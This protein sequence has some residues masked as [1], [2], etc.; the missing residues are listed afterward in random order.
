MELIGLR[1]HGYDGEH[2][3]LLH[4]GP[5]LKGRE[6]ERERETSCEHRSQDMFQTLMST[7]RTVSMCQRLLGLCF[8]AATRELVAMNDLNSGSAT[9]RKANTS[10]MMVR[11]LFLLTR[12]KESSSARRRIETS[13]SFRQSRMVL[14][15]RWTAL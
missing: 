4:V 13:L 14:R 11:M 3:F 7:V 8:S 10:F 15:C 1:Q 12:A 6:M 9:S 5:G 2:Q